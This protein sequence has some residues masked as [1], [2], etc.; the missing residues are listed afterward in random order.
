MK[1][2]VSLVLLLLAT[3]ASNIEGASVSVSTSS[4]IS[5]T[6][7]MSYAPSITAS[8]VASISASAVPPNSVYNLQ[9]RCPSTPQ[10]LCLFY[11]GSGSFASYQ[12]TLTNSSGNSYVYNTPYTQASLTSVNTGNFFVPGQTYMVE[13]RG[14]S[15]GAPTGSGA[16]LTISKPLPPSTIPPINNSTTMFIHTINC[17]LNTATQAVCTFSKGTKRFKRIK[18]LVTC[19]SNS[20]G[21][22]TVYDPQIVSG[23]GSPQATSF[24]TVSLLTS[25]ECYI[26]AKA[27]YKGYRKTRL[28]DIVYT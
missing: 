11:Q 10:T 26:R 4:S 9:D 1:T 21:A 15:G 2:I 23:T 20:N 6:M 16:M 24:T 27:S 7:S 25:A 17:N 28:R 18:V 19:Y 5:T 3:L 14:I 8:L 13:V 22:A 12:I